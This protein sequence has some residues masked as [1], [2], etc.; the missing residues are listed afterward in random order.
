MIKETIQTRIEGEIRMPASSLIRFLIGIGIIGFFY[1][2]NQKEVYY[3]FKPIPGHQWSK[4]QDLVF[5]IDSLLVDTTGYLSI[6]IEVAH[7]INY[8][9]KNIFL[10]VEHSANDS[11]LLKDTIASEL[12]DKKG[13]WIGVGNGATRQLSIPYSS[14]VQI[15]TALHHKIAIRHAMQDLNLKG[16]EKIGLK[17][18]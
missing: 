16:I 18:N 4:E 7:N 1:S 3:K 2:C 17:I 9:Y 5:S 6:S 10:S 12:V 13:R 8:P 15:D 11:I 14:R